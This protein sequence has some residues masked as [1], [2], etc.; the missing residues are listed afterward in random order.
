M[1]VVDPPLGRQDIPP[2][3]S[4]STVGSDVGPGRVL[5]PTSNSEARG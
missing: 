4:C 3:P 1:E 2:G 5:P